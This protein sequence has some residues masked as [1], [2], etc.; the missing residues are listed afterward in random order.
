VLDD[1]RIFLATRRLKIEGEE[2]PIP[3]ENS[4]EARK[5]QKVLTELE[6]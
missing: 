4:E 2:I 6:N 3:E 5:L 1:A